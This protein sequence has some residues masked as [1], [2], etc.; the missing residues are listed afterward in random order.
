MV[1][2]EA[3]ASYIPSTRLSNYER[4]QE[5]EIDDHFIE[6]KIGVR[7]RA[8]K[9][10]DE[11]T[12]DL[13]VKAYSSLR[14]KLAFDVKR[15]ETV[16]VV[17]QNPDYKIPHT[18]AVL[19]DKLSLPANCACFDI[20]LGCTGF[21]HGLSII[22]AFMTQNEMSNGLLF[23]ADPYSRIVDDNDKN[24]ALLFGDGAT[25]T[26]LTKSPVFTT[27]KFVFTTYG[28]EHKELMCMNERLYMN[29]RGVF[30][31]TVQNAEENIKKLL[32]ANAVTMED[33]DAYV[34]HQGSKYIVD[35]IRNRLAIPAHK[36][37]YDMSEY[38][39][40]ISSSIPIILEKLTGRPEIH[41]VAISGFGVGLAFANGIL[42]RTR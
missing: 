14:E 10:A 26:F 8:R 21:V 42:T 37:I 11:Q 9:M 13:C 20:S 24:T 27:G 28:K 2:I 36:V 5:F 40:T 35:M 32:E 3:I 22:Q 41:T 12:S 17:T 29:G 6:N 23:T 38:G 7:Y 18:S 34:F 4:K 16:V 39:N 31:F 19:H 33:I 15:I 25:V 1:G 30:N